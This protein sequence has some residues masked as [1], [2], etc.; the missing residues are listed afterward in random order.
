MNLGIEYCI[1]AVSPVYNHLFLPGS[2][3]SLFV[4]AYIGAEGHFIALQLLYNFL[5]FLGFSFGRVKPEFGKI[6]FFFPFADV[7]PNPKAHRLNI[8]VPNVIGVIGVAVVAGVFQ[9]MFYSIRNG[10]YMRNIIGPPGN[11]FIIGR[12]YKLHYYQYYH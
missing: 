11:S 10:H 9:N 1:G 7:V 5:H 2:K 4:Q 12:R 8:A 3:R 6:Y